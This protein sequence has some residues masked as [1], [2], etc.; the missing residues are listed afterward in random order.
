[1]VNGGVT[2]NV[3]LPRAV[4]EG[5]YQVW[6]TTPKGDTNKLTLT[7]SS[8][9][10]GGGGGG[11]TGGAGVHAPPMIYSLNPSEVDRAKCLASGGIR[12]TINGENFTTTSENL[13][14]S[15]LGGELHQ[16]SSDGRTLYFKAGSYTD[17]IPCVKPSLDPTNDLDVY[18]FIQNAYGTSDMKKFKVK[19]LPSVPGF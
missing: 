2:L 17:A 15:S 19:G 11:G 13:I 10:G 8:G 18:V 5:V 4:V 6:V 12:F 9:T 16:V 1:M 14:K 3:T 7:V